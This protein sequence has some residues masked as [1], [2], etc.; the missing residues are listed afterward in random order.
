VIDRRADG[1]DAVVV[2][3]GPNG[4]VAALVLAEAGRRVLLLE[5]GPRVGGGLRTEEL[6]LPG[7]RH[8]VGAT[9]L[10]LGL[11]SPAL[12][13]LDLAAEGVLFDQPALPL[14]HPLDVV[15]GRPAEGSAVLVHRDVAATAA[16]LG[17]DGAAWRGLLGAAAAAGPGLVDG[18]LAPPG[19]PGSSGLPGPR[20]LAALARFGAAAALPATVLARGRF[21]TERGR[22]VLGGL[23]AHSVLD[24]RRPV[25]AGVGL[26]LGV[27]AHQVGWP[28][29]RGG[30]QLLA[31]AL[32]AR[33]V[34][35]GGEVRTGVRVRSAADLP[36]AGTVVLDL[37]PR[38]VLAVLGERLPP[39][40]RAGLHRYRYGPGVFKVDW[41]LDGPV[42]WLDPAAAGA[43]TLH[44]GGPL[45]E[46]VHSER[47]VSSGRHPE[48]PYVLAVQP[49]VADPTR[50]PAGKHVLW[51]YCHVPNGSD[52]D[53]TAAIEAQ[54]ERFAPGFRERVLARHV[55]PPAALEAFDANLVGG[56]VG[57]GEAALRQLLAR[58]VLS[59]APWRMP[60]PGHYLCSSSTPPGGGAHGMGGWHAARLAL[61]DGRVSR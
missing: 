53:R 39:R 43:G 28:V 31:D 50:A 9:V 22:A 48:R 24:L 27:L 3:A 7:F 37:T 35:L 12:R 15:A 40:Y 36:A 42:P 1:F 38:Q 30:S 59:T 34:R 17:R 44:L 18:V 26:L 55:L 33:L 20:T 19:T 46:M 51:A 11:A 16:G 6:T 25:T 61:R 57:G 21:R 54:V 23:A 13:S 56:D 14:A 2:G 49:T 5:A 60:L 47:E 41:A 10:A 4:L 32:A 58:P 8:D 52:L 45:A 29:V